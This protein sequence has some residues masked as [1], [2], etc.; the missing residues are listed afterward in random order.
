MNV[1]EIISGQYTI[2]P[3]SHHPSIY[4]PKNI[5]RL[6][7]KVKTGRCMSCINKNP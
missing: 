5:I 2:Q 3:S 1:I 7:T 4:L 6:E